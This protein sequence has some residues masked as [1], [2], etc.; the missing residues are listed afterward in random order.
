MKRK[1]LFSL[2]ALCLCMLLVPNTSSAAVSF[3]QTWGA[4]GNGE[5]KFNLPTGVATDSSGN[6]YIVDTGNNRIQKFSENGIFLSQWGSYGTDS[7]QFDGPSFIAIDSLDN[8][9]VA[10]QNNNRI[11]KLSKEGEFIAELTDL[12]MVSSVAI[13]SYGNLYVLDALGITKYDSNLQLI[14]NTNWSNAPLNQA[15]DIAIDSQNN[16]Y[17]TDSGDKCVKKFDSDGNVITTWGSEGTGNGKFKY[18]NGLGIDSDDNVYI[19]DYNGNLPIQVFSSTGDFQYAFGT[20]FNSSDD[21]TFTNPTDVAIDHSGNIYVVDGTR[22]N[23]QKFVI[24]KNIQSVTNPTAKTGV[25]NGTAKTAAA[26]GLPSQIEVTLEDNSKINVNVTWDV[27]NASY[28]PTNTGAQSFTVTGT[29]TLPNGVTN[30]QNKTA[31]INVSVDAASVVVKNITDVTNPTAKTGVANGTAKTAAALGLP[32]QIEVTL[33]D[34]SKIN[35][36]VTWDVANA[37]YDPTNTGAQSFTVTGTLTLPNGVTNTQ[38]KTASINVSVDAASAVVKNITDVT[39]PTAKTGVANGTA[40]TAAALGLPSQVEVTLEDNSKINVN[41]T[42]DV[43]NASYDPTNIG[44]QSFTVTGTLTL[45]NGVTNTQNKT[46]SINVSVDAAS[47]VVK[48]IT[49]V[50]NPTAKTGVT[51][52]TA[53]TAAAL[54]LPP[55]VEV[56]LEDNSKINVNVTWDVANASYNPANTG[57]QSFTVTGI[58]TLP[59]GVTNTQS[60]TASISVVV[61]AATLSGGGGGGSSSTSAQSPSPSTSNTGVEV[62]FNGKV[63]SAGTAVTAKVNDRTVTTVAVD[64]KKIGEKLVAD[65]QHAV[66][67]IPINTKSDIVVGELNGQIV[68]NMEQ[69][70]AVVE[71][72]TE[73]VSY[74]LPAQQININAISDQLGTRVNLQDIKV[75]IEISKPPAETVKIVENSAAKGEFT[76]VAPPVNFT[77]TGT[78]GDKTIDVSKFNTYVERTIAIPDGV[79]PNK[80]TTGVVVDPDGTVRHVPTK[81]VMIDGKYFVKINS[82]TNST[83][84]VVWHPLEFKDVEHHWA[85]NAVNDMGSRMVISGIGHDLFNPDQDITRAEFAA[86]MVRGLG[87]KQEDGVVPFTDVKAADWYSSAVQIAYKNNLIRGFEDGTFRPNDKITREQAMGIIA[88]AM[89]ITDLQAKL[90]PKEAGELLRPFIDAKQAS[91]WA[92]EG[93]ADCL[94]AGLVSGRNGQQLAPKEFISRAEVAAIVQR[95]LQKSELI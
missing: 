38:N 2:V 37:S 82:L 3:I 39:N 83:Y 1:L 80:I 43:A 56:T 61:N 34:N 46:A 75:H 48:N 70:Q 11:Q 64:E 68:K 31:S 69:K 41:V 71:I 23:V 7:K 36:N 9:Y 95:L 94:Q 67:T 73:N 30:T 33:E 27:A 19:T 74:R 54:G 50:T 14:D 81:V 6:V 40:K 28:D 47:A 84:S 66:I 35:V 13:D 52:G 60:K 58:L 24:I 93:I 87:I 92:K 86:I 15:I 22:A 65:G 32:S 25:A 85:K 18:P 26:L 45:P 90:Q 59:N 78:Y 77:V 88:K 55:Q 51:N 29:L 17:V 8:V 42:W 89:K 12:F 49:D 10:D 79:D 44:A 72:K 53:K 57:T 5:G 76:I 91:E 63:E 4:G 16:L 20:P 62:L 21:T